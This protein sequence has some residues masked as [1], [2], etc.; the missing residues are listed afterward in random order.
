M[1]QH[2]LLLKLANKPEWCE[3]ELRAL[4]RGL[5]GRTNRSW[6]CEKTIGLVIND[7]DFPD[8]LVSRI[9]HLLEPFEDWELLELT[10]RHV[11]KNGWIS[12]MHTGISDDFRR[13]SRK[14][15]NPKKVA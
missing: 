9:E 5:P 7:P 12:P 14:R 11:S 10:G 6:F 3:K 13:P 4:L 8:V 2:L 1:Q 15:R